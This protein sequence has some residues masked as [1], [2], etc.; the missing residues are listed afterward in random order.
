[1][2]KWK[3]IWRQKRKKIFDKEKIRGGNENEKSEKLK[4][5]NIEIENESENIEND[6]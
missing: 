5:R 3:E 4:K 6:C 1:M 2:R